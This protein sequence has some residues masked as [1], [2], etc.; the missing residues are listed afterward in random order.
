MCP[1]P[2]NKDIIEDYPSNYTS[3][4]LAEDLL[5]LKAA[6]VKLARRLIGRR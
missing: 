6:I 5:W 1:W 3:P 2:Y 4:D